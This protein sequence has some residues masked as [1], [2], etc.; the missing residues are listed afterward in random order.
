MINPNWV[1]CPHIRY[2]VKKKPRKRD[3]IA[4]NLVWH[5]GLQYILYSYQTKR[6]WEKEFSEMT[7]KEKLQE[8][9]RKGNIFFAKELFN[10]LQLKF[11]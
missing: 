2:F 11:K 8:Y 3:W 7:N 9:I 10:E 4:Q 5:Y 1:Q 6:Y